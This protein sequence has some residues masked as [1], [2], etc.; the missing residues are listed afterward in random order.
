MQPGCNN[1]KISI[2]RIQLL[3][4]LEPRQLFCFRD[5]ETCILRIGAVFQQGGDELVQ[6]VFRCIGIDA[7]VSN[8]QILFIEP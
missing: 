3:Y 2:C 6:G 5:T 8:F 1:D 4:G 7:S